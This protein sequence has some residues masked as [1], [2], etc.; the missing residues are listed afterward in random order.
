[1]ATAK[2]NPATAPDAENKELG[3]IQGFVQGK[4]Q[5]LPPLPKGTEVPVMRIRKPSGRIAQINADEW[6]PD[7]QEAASPEDEKIGEISLHAK[8][9]KLES[10]AR[11][12][13]IKKAV[14]GF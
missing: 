4:S 5:I 12:A 3:E 9:V 2:N 14:R 7:T 10:D 11:L 1:M 13:A 8:Q 6:D